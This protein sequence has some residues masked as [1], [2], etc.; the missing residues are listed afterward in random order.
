MA[1]GPGVGR[2]VDL[3]MFLGEFVLPLVAGGQVHVGRPIDEALVERWGRE[4]VRGG[5]QVAAVDEARAVVAGELVVRPPRMALCPADLRLAAAA[6]NLLLLGHPE[7]P[8]R[9]ARA[10]VLGRALTLS[11]AEP[12]TN[13]RELLGRHA[14]LRGLF[15]VVRKDQHITWWAGSRELL[16][17]EPARRLLLWRRLRRVR[18]EEREASAYGIIPADEETCEVLAS[19][20]AASPLTDLLTAGRKRPSFRWQGQIP[21]LR[22]AELA[23]SIAY[24]WMADLAVAAGPVKGETMAT[25]A[26]GEPGSLA[27]ASLAWRSLLTAG[28]PA[29]DVRAVTAFVVHLA[30]LVVA[31]EAE[32]AGG[33][34][35]SSLVHASLANA[36]LA[37]RGGEPTGIGLLFAVPEVAARVDDALGWPPGLEAVPGVA[38]R[39][40]ARRAQARDALGWTLVDELAASLAAALAHR[41]PLPGPRRSGTISASP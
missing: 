26:A 40:R 28:L 11:R 31:A 18:V 20:L 32:P 24:S 13:R 23:R 7:L 30:C 25:S 33:D 36:A 35:V 3:A 1:T 9:R 41:A 4:L 17:Q 22:D 38:G 12:C 27:A 16:G 19:L 39:F 2:P 6:Y 37:A 5:P 21:L 10:R 29:A 14:L 15:R 8:G 34:V